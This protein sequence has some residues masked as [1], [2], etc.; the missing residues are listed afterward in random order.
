MPAFAPHW[1]CE[2]T[3]G[4][5]A[6][7]V[8]FL[9]CVLCVRRKKRLEILTSGAY[10]KAKRDFLF[11]MSLGG[12]GVV[13]YQKRFMS[14]FVELIYDECKIQIQFLVGEPCKI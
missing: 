6:T 4:P 14:E 10:P 5:C 7:V 3:S 1:G 9:T 2:A 13:V 8:L 11:R 12:C